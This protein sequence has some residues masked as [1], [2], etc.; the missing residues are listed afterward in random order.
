[1]PHAEYNPKSITHTAEPE[2]IVFDPLNS[3]DNK[4]PTLGALERNFDLEKLVERAERKWE[5]NMTEKIV[6]G[7]YEVLDT[8]GENVSLTRSRKKGPKG[9]VD[10][11]LSKQP[12]TLVDEEDGFELI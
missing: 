12:C 3:A 7:E 11:Q 9:K 5:I 4:W 1:M 8:E 2:L 10:K 6:E